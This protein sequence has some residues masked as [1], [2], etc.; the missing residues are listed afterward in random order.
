MATRSPNLCRNRS[1]VCGVREISGTIMIAVFPI[2]R[3]RWMH[4]MYISVLPLPVTPWSRKDSNFPTSMAILSF[5]NTAFCPGVNVREAPKGWVNVP[6]ATK[7]SRSFLS[8]KISTRFFSLRPRSAAWH[9]GILVCSSG[10]L[11][12]FCFIRSNNNFCLGLRLSRLSIFSSSGKGLVG[13]TD[14]IN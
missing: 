9:F 3:M 4:R 2:S 5:S 13:R 14:L 6:S 7:A 12:S 1:T 11:I 8:V 10:R